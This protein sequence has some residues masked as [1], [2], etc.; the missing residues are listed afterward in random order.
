MLVTLS[1]RQQCCLGMREA[2]DVPGQDDGHMPPQLTSSLGTWKRRT[3]V[4]EESY[5]LDARTACPFMHNR[6]WAHFRNNNTLADRRERSLNARDNAL[7]S[8]A[9]GI[10]GYTWQARTNATAQMRPKQVEQEM[11]CADATATQSSP[12]VA[13]IMLAGDSIARAQFY[14]LWCMLHVAANMP[15]SSA[16]PT[17]TR[18]SSQFVDVTVPLTT[19]QHVRLVYAG[20]KYLVDARKHV[21]AR[22]WD[23]HVLLALTRISGRPPPTRFAEPRTKRARADKRRRR[24]A[25]GEFSAEENNTITEEELRP[26]SPPPPFPPPPPTPPPPPPPEPPFPPPP[27]PPKRRPK[28]TRAL[29]LLAGNHFINGALADV[30]SKWSTRLRHF[31]R[32]MGLAVDDEN[33]L[34]I[35]AKRYGITHIVFIS[36][37]AQHFDKPWNRG[38]VCMD[39][40]PFSNGTKLAAAS[41]DGGIADDGIGEMGLLPVSAGDQWPSS[42]QPELKTMML[43]VYEAVAAASAGHPLNED[44]PVDLAARLTRRSAVLDALRGNTR[45]TA[46]GMRVSMID[47][48]AMTKERGDAHCGRLT[49]ESSR[50]KTM[51]CAHYC[52]PGP[53][54]AINRAL[55]YRLFH[56]QCH[57]N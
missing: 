14:S 18:D 16:Q 31:R 49:G 13:T 48:T 24:R 45:I 11:Q 7:L 29:V 55:L 44:E 25:V 19:T 39:T 10:L 42:V 5:A 34:S 41:N 54:D 4:D 1:S 36:P 51:D 22:K 12:N 35:F 30:A 33:T 27:P 57:A 20:A 17:Y 40:A 6:V 3:D 53:P 52:L 2:V 26:P 23:P 46:S 32:I 8:R 43:D 15:A 56:G 9:A 37:L 28:P 21:P 50:S 38:G 47:G